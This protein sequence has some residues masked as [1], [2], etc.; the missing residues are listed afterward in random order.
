[1]LTTGAVNLD[2]TNAPASTCSAQNYSQAT[3]CTVEVTFA[4][5]AVGL[6]MGAV[7]FYSEANNSG[8]ALATV[9]IYGIGIGP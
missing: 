1:M 8:S 6:R 7:V 5:S 3:Q 4:P 2:F 9:P